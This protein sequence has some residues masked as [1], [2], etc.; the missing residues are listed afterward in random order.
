[1]LFTGAFLAATTPIEAQGLFE[2]LFAPG[3]SGTPPSGPVVRYAPREIGPV[4][5]R[6][7]NSRLGTDREVRI[8]SLEEL[9]GRGSRRYVE[10]AK[11]GPYL[12]PPELP[13]HLGRFLRDPTLRPGD[14]VATEK[15]LMV[16]RGPGGSR[17]T[18]DQ[19]VPV[20]SAKRLVG[21]KLPL[22]V[23]MD[24][25]LKKSPRV[26]AEPAMA[27]A[28]NA[29]QRYAGSTCRPGFVCLKSRR[30]SLAR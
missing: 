15:G 17:H 6:A 4:W 10:P 8:P 23:K 27:A 19:F 12:P 9:S 11:P 21:D 29:E 25:E 20:I 2:I 13:G 1:M 24:R 22:L 5:R 14:V 16:Y 26:L 7:P 28:Y 3:G 18:E 30:L